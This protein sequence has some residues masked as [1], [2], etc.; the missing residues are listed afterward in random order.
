MEKVGFGLLFSLTIFFFCS[1]A[2]NSI[3]K[4]TEYHH[5]FKI[6]KNT[7]HEQQKIP[8]FIK[9]LRA[10]DSKNNLRRPE[11][12]QNGRE[13]PRDNTL[14]NKWE[15]RGRERWAVKNRGL[16]KARLLL[17]HRAKL[18]SFACHLTAL[19]DPTAAKRTVP[20]IPCHKRISGSRQGAMEVPV[21][22]ES[23]LDEKVT[24]VPCPLPFVRLG[25]GILGFQDCMYVPQFVL[26]KN[27]PNFISC[28]YY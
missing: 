26:W 4:T 9:I 5:I 27:L 11:E 21:L 14:N 3:R 13:E 15:E 18:P 10:R 8:A 16:R 2:C 22:G 20:S 24:C 7:K 19:T 1:P 6:K 28:R 12:D 23:S 17:P 25:Y